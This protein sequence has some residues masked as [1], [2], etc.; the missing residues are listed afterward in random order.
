M[1]VR[2][3]NCKYV[4]TMIP[5]RQYHSVLINSGRN[6]FIKFTPLIYNPPLAEF[7]QSCICMVS[8]NHCGKADQFNTGQRKQCTCIV[9]NVWYS[10]GVTLHSLAS[11][12]LALL[13]NLLIA[14]HGVWFIT[15]EE[16]TQD[17]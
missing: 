7:Y 5:E 14:T 10:S 11:N 12:L 8:K 13:S 17:Y 2:L 1:N 3:Y 4:S 6:S 16:L 15:D 9:M